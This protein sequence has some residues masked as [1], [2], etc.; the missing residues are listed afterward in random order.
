MKVK[1]KSI[2]EPQNFSPQTQLDFFINYYVQN[3]PTKAS[4]QVN[5][6]MMAFIGYPFVTQ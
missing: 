5:L 3:M 1:K 6:F 2:T 4:R